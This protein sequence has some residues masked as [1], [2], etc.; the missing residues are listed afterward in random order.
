MGELVGYDL[1]SSIDYI[2]KLSYETFG[3]K[4]LSLFCW[5]LDAL[6]P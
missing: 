6:I 1:S 5:D 4:S 2:Y 3:D